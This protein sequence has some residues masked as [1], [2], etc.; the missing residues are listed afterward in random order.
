METLDKITDVILK[1][2]PDIQGVYLFGSYGTEDERPDSDVDV[3]L[4]LPPMQEGME[5]ELQLSRCQASLV[6]LLRRDVD[7]TS[8]TR[9]T[10]RTL[11]K[12]LRLH[13]KRL[14]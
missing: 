10:G 14:R 8:Q 3:A 9:R 5:P 13:L 7:R 4:L 2:Y 11:T 6:K 1:H 12:F